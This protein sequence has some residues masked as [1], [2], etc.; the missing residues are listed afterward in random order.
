MVKWFIESVTWFKANGEFVRNK[1]IW[2]M[3]LAVRRNKTNGDFK[4]RHLTTCF[5]VIFH[6]V[7][8]AK[9]KQGQARERE[10][11]NWRKSAVEWT[12]N[13]LQ[14]R[15]I[16]RVHRRSHL[17]GKKKRDAALP[18][19][20]FITEASSVTRLFGPP[21]SSGEMDQSVSSFVDILRIGRQTSLRPASCNYVASSLL[22]R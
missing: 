16:S 7:V 4:W 1:S 17:K 20:E 14:G 8:R 11:T 6:S 9:G 15:K 18:V 5:P 2:L 3:Q 22:M 12:R 10:A 21:C 13:D 19:G